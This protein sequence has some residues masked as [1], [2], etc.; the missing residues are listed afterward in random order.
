MFT[1][2]TEYAKYKDIGIEL[3]RYNIEG[4]TGPSNTSKHNVTVKT[5]SLA[6]CHAINVCVCCFSQ[7]SRH[8][9]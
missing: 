6:F 4:D 8:L 9:H 7:S 2:G 5:E 3:Q 1:I